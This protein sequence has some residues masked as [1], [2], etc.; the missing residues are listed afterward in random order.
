MNIVPKIEAHAFLAAFA[1][2]S[3]FI[4]ILLLCVYP[5]PDKNR[6]LVIQL[7]TMYVTGCAIGAYNYYF[8]NSNSKKMNQPEQLQENVKPE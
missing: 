5:I 6:D 1:V 3:S 8:G 2:V 7:S 4:L